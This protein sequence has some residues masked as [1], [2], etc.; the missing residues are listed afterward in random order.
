MLVLIEDFGKGYFFHEYFLFAL[1]ILGDNFFQIFIKHIDLKCHSG[2]L[3]G[4]LMELSNFLSDEEN[5]LLKIFPI[6]FK[7]LQIICINGQSF[8]QILYYDK[9]AKFC[10]LILLFLVLY[11]LRGLG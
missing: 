5:F 6:V 10:L 11:G 2:I 4:Q 1:M 7:N 3:G 9:I 8:L